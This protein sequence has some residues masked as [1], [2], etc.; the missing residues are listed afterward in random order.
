[1]KYKALTTEQCF[2]WQD[3]VKRRKGGD[4]LPTKLLNRL[5]I[6][7]THI[8][9]QSIPTIMHDGG[10]MGGD[11]VRALVLFKVDGSDEP[12][13]GYYGIPTRIFNAARTVTIETDICSVGDCHK[14]AADGDSYCKAHTFAGTT[15]RGSDGRI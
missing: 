14:P 3:E 13:T 4:L 5:D 6:E 10:L 7:G 1:M 11:S 8:I 12:V 9:D 2:E 15:G